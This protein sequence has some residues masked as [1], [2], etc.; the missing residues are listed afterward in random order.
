MYKGAKGVLLKRLA[1]T[2]DREKGFRF[3]A[4]VL[5]DFSN[6]Q[7]MVVV[8][9]IWIGS[10]NKK[11]RERNQNSLLKLHFPKEIQLEKETR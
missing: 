5:E 11:Q 3:T 2:A 1:G 6:V 9:C 10:E 7:C 4:V 8:L